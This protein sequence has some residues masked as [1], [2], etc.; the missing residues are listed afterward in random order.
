M[1]E[2]CPAEQVIDLEDEALLKGMV[3]VWCNMIEPDQLA[4][5]QPYSCKFA[6]HRNGL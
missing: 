4:I 1:V 2:S 5:V 6:A 3:M